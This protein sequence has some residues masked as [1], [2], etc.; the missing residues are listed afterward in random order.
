LIKKVF[1]YFPHKEKQK[2]KFGLPYDKD[3]YFLT[4]ILILDCFR[5]EAPLIFR[6]IVI[7]IACTL[8]AA[9]LKGLKIPDD[10][11]TKKTKSKNKIE[12]YRE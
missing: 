2:N 7:T 9:S 8:I 3:M 1:I 6:P 5:T 11:I 4:R 12:I 10:L